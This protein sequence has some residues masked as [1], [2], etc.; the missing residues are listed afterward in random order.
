M[1]S[2]YS[3]S[4][5][6]VPLQP[7]I[8]SILFHHYKELK[9]CISEV[10]QIAAAYTITIHYSNEKNRGSFVRVS[11]TYAYCFFGQVPLSLIVT[12]T[13]PC[14]LNYSS[15]SFWAPPH[16]ASTY[17]PVVTSIIIL[18]PCRRGFKSSHPVHFF[19]Q[20]GKIWY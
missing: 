2:A 8:I 17:A 15:N 1:I 6:L 5:Q 12:L 20:S 4:C 7:I 3:N 16:L 14:T 19:Y 11:R 13:L 18:M 10:K 9:E